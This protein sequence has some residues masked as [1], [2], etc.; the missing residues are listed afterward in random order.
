MRLNDHN[1]VSPRD[2][3]PVPEQKSA[4]IPLVHLRQE[5]DG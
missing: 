4:L 3:R 2:H 1:V 5:Q